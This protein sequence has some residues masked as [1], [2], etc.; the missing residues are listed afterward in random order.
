MLNEA[1]FPR[2]LVIGTGI[3]LVLLLTWQLV[4]LLLLVFA[5]VLVAIFF[6]SLA[7]V[8]AKQT[9]ISPSWSLAIAVVLVAV[10]FGLITTLFGTTIRQNVSTLIEQLP[11]AWQAIRGRIGEVRWLVDAF[12]RAGQALLTSN[13][14][15]RIGGALGAVMGAFT[16]IFLVLF[17]GLYIAAQPGLYRSGFL[18]LVPPQDRPRIDATLVRCGVFLR[19]WLLGQLIAMV[20]VGTL[21]WAGLQLLQVPSALAL[22]L[23]AGLAE[24]VPILGPIAAAI[25]ALIIAF[26]QDSRLALWVLALFVVIQQLEGN[27]L[28]PII[29]RRMVALPP[30]V[31]LFA[32]IAF[33]ILFGAMGALLATPLAV[34]T[35]VL[36]QDLYIAPIE[37]AAT[38]RSNDS[39]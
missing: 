31:T 35:L 32:V 36:V 14:M 7:N 10:F 38:A 18:K 26:S 3:V 34:V 27:V 11:A 23:F 16:N 5:S 39:G 28:Q 29:Q 19:N 15:S 2:R 1:N 33:A 13:M 6:R 25:P 37:E 4:D 12:D 30:A 21:T 22:G 24:F 20:V 9:T 17:A 8:I